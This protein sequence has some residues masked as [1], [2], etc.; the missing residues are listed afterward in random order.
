MSEA[1]QVPATEAA[2]RSVW[3]EI[4]MMEY[5]ITGNMMQATECADRIEKIYKD[6]VRA[7]TLADADDF[8]MRRGET[9]AAYL[10]RTCDVP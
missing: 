10:I 4:C 9:S 1:P 7:E 3:T 5:R 8:L 2:M 6:A